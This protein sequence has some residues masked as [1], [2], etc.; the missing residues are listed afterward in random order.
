MI[1]EDQARLARN[2]KTAR[3]A[4][5]VTQEAAAKAVGKSRQTIVNWENPTNTAEPSSS[6][7]AIL[8]ERYGVSAKDL[9]FAPLEL[10]PAAAQEEP[11]VT[12]PAQPPEPP[13]DTYILRVGGTKTPPTS[14]KAS[15]E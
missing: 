4:R 2:L 15:K 8:A 5:R 7:L 12:G 9:R 14:G 10:R 6:E 13:G 3:E 11:G 1:N